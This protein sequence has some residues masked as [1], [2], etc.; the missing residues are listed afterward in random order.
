MCTKCFALYAPF[1]LLWLATVHNTLV[2]KRPL[3]DISL[4][5]NWQSRDYLMIQNQLSIPEGTKMLWCCLG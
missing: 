3:T 4:L 1:I 5:Q 2:S